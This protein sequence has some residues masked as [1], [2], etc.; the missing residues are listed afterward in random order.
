MT[1]L[2]LL[3]HPYHRTLLNTASRLLSQKEPAVALV[4]AHMACEIYTEQILALALK[5]RALDDEL[6][7][8]I[9]KLARGHISDKRIRRLYSALTGD[10]IEHAPF[11]A[12]FTASW[13][14]R[15]KAVHGGVKVSIDQGREACEIAR[16]FVA[17]LDTVAKK[18]R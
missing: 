5:K 15:G 14:L 16:E 17:R 6:E 3:S 9:T 1:L 7:S 13:V 11:W 2:L 8:A 10:D 18:L 4:V 12:R